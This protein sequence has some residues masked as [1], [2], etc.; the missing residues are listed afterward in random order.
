MKSSLSLIKRVQQVCMYNILTYVYICIIMAMISMY[1][2]RVVHKR[3]S[4]L[5]SEGLST[6]FEA[7]TNIYFTQTLYVIVVTCIKI[8]SK[9][10]S[11]II[12]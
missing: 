1:V 4:I 8:A 12:S 10:L 2:H 7:S 9:M 11:Y 6:T 5:T 3:M